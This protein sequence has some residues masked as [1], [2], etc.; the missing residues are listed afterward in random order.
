MSYK[1]ETTPPF[2][3]QAKKLTKKYPSLKSDLLQLVES[4][5][6]NPA[7]GTLLGNNHQ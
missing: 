2:E 1:V 3:K 4:L 7:Q 5:E 6:T